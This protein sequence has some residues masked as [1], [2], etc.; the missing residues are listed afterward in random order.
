MRYTPEIIANLKST[1]RLQ[2][3]ISAEHGVVKDLAR[4]GVIV[5][6]G[7]PVGSISGWV[8]ALFWQVWIEPGDPA[9]AVHV[10][11]ETGPKEQWRLDESLSPEQLLGQ[12]K[13]RWIAQVNEQRL[14][15]LADAQKRVEQLEHAA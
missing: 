14:A 3:Q 11:V 12:A 15:L 13:D 5:H 9:G 2:A 1:G 6:L 4:D 10:R 8:G 7:A